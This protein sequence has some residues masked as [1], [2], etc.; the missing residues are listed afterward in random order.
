MDLI[1]RARNSRAS[2]QSFRQMRERSKRYAYGRQWDDIVNVDGVQ[3]READYIRSQGSIPLKN[4]L[5]RKLIRSVLGVFRN[6]WRLPSPADLRLNAVIDAETGQI[7]GPDAGRYRRIKECYELNNLDELFARTMEEFLLS[8]LA[9]F[10]LSPD[11][12]LPS[13]PG[14]APVGTT[15]IDF[16]SPENFFFD[17]SSKDFR[18]WDANL[19]GEIH[20]LDFQTLCANFAKSPDDLKR[21]GA[22][23]GAASNRS[24]EG[25]L[26]RVVEVWHL[27]A[28]PRYRIHDRETGTLY[29]ME[30]VDYERLT[31]SKRKKLK[32]VWFCDKVWRYSFMTPDGE[33]LTE[34]DSPL[35]DGGHPYVWRAYP[36][37]DGEIH[38][39]VE[40]VID[41]QRFT[42]RLITLYDWVLRSSAKGVLLFPQE[43]VPQGADLQDVVDEWSRFNGVIVYKAKSGLP[44]P[45]QVSGAGQQKGITDLL[46]IQLK[47][48]EDISGVNS[49]LQG[50]LDSNVTSGTLYDS[51]T[52]QALTSLQDLLHTYND[53][54]FKLLTSVRS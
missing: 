51:Q 3:M 12:P 54:L 13:L 16:V 39:F 50:R 44:A 10:R 31:A 53:L 18:G 28:P 30:A 46:D 43:S 11:T 8:G 36:F 38:S 52:R 19:I 4:N 20:Y 7:S 6:N 34:G 5:I 23:Y 27:D 25:K 15:R 47:M 21:L 41:Q 1:T 29:K 32:G 37:V 42:N 17:T 48:F 40:D 45:Q 26:C 35:P 33:V 49:A 24:A 22:L 2:L 14:S 9:V